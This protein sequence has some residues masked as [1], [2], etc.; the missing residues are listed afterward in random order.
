MPTHTPS[1]AVQAAREALAERLVDLRRNAGLQAREV[2]ALCGWHK[3]KVS[4]LENART[5]PS[6]DDIR[7]WCRACGAEE[8]LDDLI[9]ATRSAESMYVEWKRLQR[10]GLR[11]LQEEIAPLFDRTRLFRVYCA[12]PVPGLLQTHGYAAAML[13]M[14]GAFHG[15]K[16]DFEEAAAA[17]VHRS[18]VIHGPGRRAVLLVEEAALYHQVGSPSVMA[19]QL[20]YLLEVM[21]L[22]SVSLGVIPFRGERDMWAVETFGVYDD[23]QVGVELLTARV[24]V[25]SPSEVRMYLRAFERLRHM[26]VY[27]L[28]ARSRITAAIDALE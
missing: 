16:P 20:G 5:P 4:R 2:A 17:R 13:K 3:S 1:S 24:T 22:P 15:T 23:R 14:Y 26:A 11:Q 12:H 19:G 7:R 27:G 10:S 25:T 28:E 8:H 21:S 18:R 9:A 6:D